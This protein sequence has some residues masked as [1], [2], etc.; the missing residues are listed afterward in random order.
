VARAHRRGDRA[1][2]YDRE[3]KEKG[4][5]NKAREREREERSSAEAKY[6]CRP[7]KRCI[8]AACTR[9]SSGKWAEY[10]YIYTGVL[11]NFATLYI[12]RSSPRLALA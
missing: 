10:I 12:V 1:S 11:F 9:A 3:S 5:N 6:V 4:G 2:R 7:D 8:S